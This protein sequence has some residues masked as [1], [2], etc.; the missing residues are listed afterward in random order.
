MEGELVAYAGRWPGTPEEGVGKYKLP[1]GFRKN[2]E[3][4]NQHRAASCDSDSPLV[5]VEGYLDA[6]KLHQAGYERVVAVMG[7]SLSTEQEACLYRLCEADER[8][9]LFFDNDEA[10]RKGQADALIRLS[11]RLYVHTVDLGS[12]EVQPEHLSPD[13]LRA[14]LPFPEGRLP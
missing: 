1:Q 9:V 14:L 3:L 12:R 11:K 5:V 13:E 2:I 10:G 4:F 7:S 6:I 8:V